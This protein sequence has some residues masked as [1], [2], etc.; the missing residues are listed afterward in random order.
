MTPYA[1]YR[2]KELSKGRNENWSP[3]GPGSL[4]WMAVPAN[5]SEHR[6]ERKTLKN[7]Q[8]G[9]PKLGAH[10]RASAAHI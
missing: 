2:A 7:Y 10:S 3:E 5:L 9:T 1:R 8:E 6:H 4:T